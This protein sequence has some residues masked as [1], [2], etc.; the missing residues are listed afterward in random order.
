MTKLNF[1]DTPSLLYSS[2]V[3][4]AGKH[5]NYPT[6]CPLDAEDSAAI[7]NNFHT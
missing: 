1:K 6:K 5:E 3:I 7:S 4:C 2:I